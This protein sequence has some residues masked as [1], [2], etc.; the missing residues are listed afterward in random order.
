MV[1]Y[2]TQMRCAAVDSVMFCVVLLR[3]QSNCLHVP[4]TAAFILLGG[5]FTLK[6]QFSGIIPNNAQLIK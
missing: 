2:V 1:C 5:L 6:H 4:P 3:H